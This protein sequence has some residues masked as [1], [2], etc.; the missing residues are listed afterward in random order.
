[1]KEIEI[2]VNNFE[3]NFRIQNF[4]CREL[5]IIKIGVVIV[6]IAPVPIWDLDGI[7]CVDFFLNWKYFEVSLKK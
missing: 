5:K 7:D 2:F 1:M 3:E 4:I 6:D